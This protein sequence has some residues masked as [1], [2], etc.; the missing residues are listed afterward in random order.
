MEYKAIGQDTEKINS[1]MEKVMST[2]GFLHLTDDQKRYIRL[3]L[4]MQSRAE[5]DSDPASRDAIVSPKRYVTSETRIHPEE[6][7]MEMYEQGAGHDPRDRKYRSSQNHIANFNCHAA[8]YGMETGMGF[9]DKEIEIPEKFFNAKY[10]LVDN[11]AQLL[12][13]FEK[14]E[15]PTVVL[16]SR[17]ASKHGSVNAWHTFLLLGHD[18][19]D[20]L[21]MWHKKNM[22]LE[23][24]VISVDDFLKKN[25]PSEFE[26]G[27]R[28]INTY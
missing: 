23:Y 10:L 25:N 9:P 15:F 21:L 27:F 12:D 18:N 11:K 7:L 4:Y 13:I 16:M 24:Q 8:I 3:S 28:N 26:W 1:F 20:N 17:A 5:R 14:S 6:H 2:E 22:S 19:E